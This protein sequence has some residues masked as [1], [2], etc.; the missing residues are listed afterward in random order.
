M[1]TRASGACSSPPSPSPIAIGIRPSIVASEPAGQLWLQQGPWGIALLRPQALLGIGGLD[2]VGEAPCTALGQPAP[3]LLRARSIGRFAGGIGHRRRQIDD[4][5][6]PRRVVVPRVPLGP[7]VPRAHAPKRDRFLVADSHPLAQGLH[8]QAGRIDGLAGKLHR[9]RHPQ[10]VHAVDGLGDA[11]ILADFMLARATG[12]AVA[13]AR[14]RGCG[15]A[16]APVQ[17]RRRAR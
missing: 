9:A 1:T 4:D 10:V 3:L 6:V 12:R 7:D 14:R 8:I 11:T 13:P 2:P 16:P 17:L 15:R 5:V